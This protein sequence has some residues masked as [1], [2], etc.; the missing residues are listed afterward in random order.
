MGIV[1]I[2]IAYFLGNISAAI[3]L[4][5]LLKGE[6]VRTKGS[7]NA[8]ATNMLRNYGKGMAAATLIIDVLK[9]VIAVMI[10]AKFGM[11]Y[12]CALAVVVGH[13]YPAVFGF[14]GG[15]GIATG[16]G[17]LLAINPKLA[18]CCLA[19]A[20]I[21]FVTTKYISLGSICAAIAMPVF[22][23]FME[24]GFTIYAL[25]LCILTCYKHRENIKR[26]KNGTES[27]VGQHSTQSNQDAVHPERAPEAAGTAAE[28]TPTAPDTTMTTTETVTTETTTD[29]N[30]E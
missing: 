4:S 7:G 25:I 19:V 20:V 13:M 16:L 10:G 14:R 18:L 28:E 17:V 29:D 30:N 1:S 27:K 15:K 23:F 3:I 11:A 12:P 5:K 22:S 9:G 6:D 21:L 2:I 26:L 24:P 8:G